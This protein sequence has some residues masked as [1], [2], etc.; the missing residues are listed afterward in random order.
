MSA[1]FATMAPWL[2]IF[3]LPLM[4]MCLMGAI[5]LLRHDIR[6]LEID[7]TILAAVSVAILLLIV[8]WSGWRDA[9]ASLAFGIL[10]GA[11]TEAVRRLRPSQMG[12]GDPWALAALGLAAGPSY[13]IVSVVSLVVF[14]SFAAITYS[15]IRGKGW[16]RSMFPMALAFIP[17]IW[18]VVSL[19]A[20][21]AYEW[22]PLP[23]ALMPMQLTLEV[24]ITIIAC[25][26]AWFFGLWLGGR[27][28]AATRQQL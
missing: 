8:I 10:F 27:N 16:F 1:V 11:I 23:S 20:I 3:S 7:F 13:A 22:V 17:A 19:R 12:Q 15:L 14:G 2:A 24:S 4:L 28:R 21:A 5:L 6:Y 18:V 9:L 26:A 25:V